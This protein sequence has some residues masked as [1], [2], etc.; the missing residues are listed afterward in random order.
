MSVSLADLD[1]CDFGERWE[2]QAPIHC[3]LQC[4]SASILSDCFDCQAAEIVEPQIIARYPDRQMKLW[5]SGHPS[6]KCIGFRVHHRLGMLEHAES[7]DGTEAPVWTCGALR[8]RAC[9]GPPCT[10]RRPSC[11]HPCSGCVSP[12]LGSRGVRCRGSFGWHTTG[13][14]LSGYLTAR[15][16][17]RLSWYGGCV[18]W[19]ARAAA[20]H[21]R[22]GRGGWVARSISGSCASG[23][24]RTGDCN[25]SYAP[26]WLH[27]LR[28][29]SDAMDG[30]SSD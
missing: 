9:W 5:I 22:L 1:G 15:R 18:W 23:A 6:Q 30:S 7:P 4:Y 2:Q 28:P 12:A 20:V 10:G 21:G 8:R 25:G 26:C 29:G 17:P 16:R 3:T 19:R 11:N 27:R 13:R 24:I 14:T